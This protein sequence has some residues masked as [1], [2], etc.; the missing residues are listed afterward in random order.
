M[1]IRRHVFRY[2]W[3]RGHALHFV[4]LADPRVEPKLTPVGLVSPSSIHNDDSH[5]AGTR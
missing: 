1:Q 5:D 2:Y 3:R 4:A